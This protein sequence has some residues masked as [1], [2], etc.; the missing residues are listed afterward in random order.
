MFGL[1]KKPVGIETIPVTQTFSGVTYESLRQQ[2]RELAYKKWENAGCPW[3]QD[4]EFW[5]EAEEELFGK[6][7]LKNGGYVLKGIHKNVM[8]CPLNSENP[9]EVLV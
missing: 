3:G 1:K 7:A 2:I 5:L 9:V 6:D 4:R 8:V